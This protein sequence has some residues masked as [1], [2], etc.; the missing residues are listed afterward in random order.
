[1]STD[2]WIIRDDKHGEYLG[3]DGLFHSPSAFFQ[4]RVFSNAEKTKW[5]QSH[6]DSFCTAMTI[7]HATSRY[8]FYVYTE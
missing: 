5:L 3:S 4:I 7:D 1:M 2:Q 6:C 8:G